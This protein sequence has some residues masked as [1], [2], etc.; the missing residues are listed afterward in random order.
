MK[1]KTENTKQFIGN[2]VRERE[3]E[4]ERERGGYHEHEKRGRKKEPRESY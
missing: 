3:R 1:L 2:T 4:R